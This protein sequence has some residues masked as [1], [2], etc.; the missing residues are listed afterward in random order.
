MRDGKRLRHAAYTLHYLPNRVGHARLGLA[1]GRRVSPHAV[2]RN[3][4]KRIVRE[5]FRHLA[6]RLPALDIV[7]NARAP[8]AQL[9]RRTLAAA[10]DDAL[11]QLAVRHPPEPE[12]H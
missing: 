8:A 3:T 1:I 6:P 4:L 9:D 7:L 5:R 12:A 10:V 2:I 11:L